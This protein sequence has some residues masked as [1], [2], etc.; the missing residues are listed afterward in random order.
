[1]EG[2]CFAITSPLRLILFLIW[3]LSAYTQNKLEPRLS[4]VPCSKTKRIEK[5]PQKQ[6]FALMAIKMC[7]KT[8]SSLYHRE[9]N[10]AMSFSHKA[11]KSGGPEKSIDD[12]T[13][14][15]A[16]HSR[17]LLPFSRF[18]APGPVIRQVFNLA[19]DCSRSEIS[20]KQLKCFET[21]NFWMDPKR[22]IS[23]LVFCIF[24]HAPTNLD[25]EL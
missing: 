12:R 23:C 16:F 14:G 8:I 19:T 1:M 6:L 4:V 18:S 22:L 21:I 2:I 13:D 20:L 24:V 15:C 5:C 10:E 11:K 9:R 17:P 7:V 25:V 3:P